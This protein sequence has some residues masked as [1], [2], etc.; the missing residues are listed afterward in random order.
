MDR[1]YNKRLNIK[2]TT[3]VKKDKKRYVPKVKYKETKKVPQLKLIKFRSFGL[4][5]SS[6][7]KLA[8]KVKDT[9]IF[10]FGISFVKRLNLNEIQR[11]YKR[12]KRLGKYKPIFE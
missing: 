10:S 9:N 2:M 3:S 7:W 8:E 5:I 11:E 1:K 4:I 6:I 12:N